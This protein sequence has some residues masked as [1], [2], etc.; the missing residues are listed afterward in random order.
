MADLGMNEF[1]SS[2]MWS[3][4]QEGGSFVGVFLE[5]MQIYSLK[6]NNSMTLFFVTP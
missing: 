1:L 6:V 3:Y 5:N 4:D 2:M